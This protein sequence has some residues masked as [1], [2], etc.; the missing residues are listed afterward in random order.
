MNVAAILKL[1][2]RDVVTASPGTSLL[3]IAQ[4]LGEHKI[5]CIVIVDEGGNVS[6]IV[7]ERD[8]VRELARIGAPVM[9][10]PVEV[11]MTKS[12]VTCREADTIDRLMGEMTAHRFRHMPVVERGRL[13]GLV[14]IGDV[15]RMRIAEAEMEAAAMRDYIATG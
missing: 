4:R 14:S 8:I 15:V 2:G 9:E 7:S 5:G 3:E 6:G 10:E 12:V 13:V 11:Y 1:K